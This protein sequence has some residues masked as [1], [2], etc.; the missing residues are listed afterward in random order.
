MSTLPR[1]IFIDGLPGSGKTTTAQRLCLHL[2]A[3]GLPAR[4]YFEHEGG[5]P[6]FED[7]HV[8][9]ARATGESEPNRVLAGAL[10][11]FAA[12]AERLQTADETV[13]LE[14]TLFQTMVGTQVLM[15]VPRSE[16]ERHFDAWAARIAPVAP[17]LIYFRPRDV[18]KALHRAAERRGAWFPEFVTTH[19]SD[20]PRG[21][22]TGLKTFEDAMAVFEEH[23]AICDTLA[24]RFPGR[25]LQIDNSDGDWPS[26]ERAISDF[27]GIPP[28]AEPP[29]PLQ[30]G[31][32]TGRYRAETGDEWEIRA[33]ARGLFFVFP[34]SPRLW[35]TA[36]G[37]FAGEG[38]C[39]EL[40]FERDATG[41]VCR[42]HCAG[43]L[44][45]LPRRW[46]KL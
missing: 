35:L 44:P 32:Y 7:E 25:Q 37:A 17:A 24:R 8:R 14:S 3:L 42:A 22:R 31:D 29:A 33:D 6:I 16:I 36:S 40:T 5:H 11:R 43:D 41:V 10:A 28:I 4:W 2:R 1:L 34:G 9:L 46:E 18:V 13:I 38:A 19:V 39:L 23:R 12:L 30:A 20:T 21:R 15:D 26:H 45:K 27:L